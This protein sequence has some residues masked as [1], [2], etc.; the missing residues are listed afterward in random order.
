[1]V[2]HAHLH[3]G[4]EG[5]S[6]LAAATVGDGTC[7]LH[8]PFGQPNDRGVLECRDGRNTMQQVLPSSCAELRSS[9]PME[10]THVVT[11]VLTCIWELLRDAAMD[12]CRQIPQQQQSFVDAS[13]VMPSDR[14]EREAQLYWMNIDRDMQQE[15]L[16][17]YCQKIFEEQNK[18]ALNRQL[19]MLSCQLFCDTNEEAI[20]RPLSMFLGY[21]PDCSC[22]Y[23]A[24][25]VEDALLLHQR[26]G[27]I[28]DLSLLQPCPQNP[29]VSKYQALF[30]PEARYDGIRFW[31]FQ[32]SRFNTRQPESQ[33]VLLNSLEHMTDHAKELPATAQLLRDC[34]KTVQARSECFGEVALPQ[35]FA[36][37]HA[38]QVYRRTVVQEAYWLS[39]FEV[40]LIALLA[41]RSVHITRFAAEEERFHSL[42]SVTSAEDQ[43]GSTIALDPG[44]DQ[45]SARGHFSRIW[46]QSSWD[47]HMCHRTAAGE[48][49]HAN[50]LDLSVDFPALHGDGEKG[51]DDGGAEDSDS[52]NSSSVSPDSD[53]RSSSQS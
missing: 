53:V 45:G 28:D 24:Y 33:Q 6:Y 43:D 25:S 49:A 41:H 16:Q 27:L 32:N 47:E 4:L 36:E 9:V 39:Y 31:F 20:V 12:I 18:E 38:W 35:F 42:V 50:N 21:V 40:A 30:L 51:E 7:G 11:A 10:Y 37:E 8:A 5:L 46:P 26:H 19:Q 34:K 1:M 13:S 15:L 44:E 23:R 29:S 3:G 48:S 2:P 22:D 17:F 14:V 52:I